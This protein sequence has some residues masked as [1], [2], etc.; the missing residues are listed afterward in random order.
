MPKRNSNKANEKDSKSSQLIIITKSRLSSAKNNFNYM[1]IQ[2]GDLKIKVKIKNEHLNRHNI[3]KVIESL[4]ENTLKHSK[5]HG[6]LINKKEIILDDSIKNI[7]LKKKLF[8]KIKIQSNFDAETVKSLKIQS[9]ENYKYKINDDKKEY[10]INTKPLDV[11]HDN[12]SDIINEDNIINI[13]EKEEK[14]FDNNLNSN[15]KFISHNFFDKNKD[16]FRKK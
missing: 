1:T 15:N 4:K 6:K 13:N 10:E 7:N 16:N 14:N 12:N 8:K 3:S 9:S 2:E 11:S 5:S